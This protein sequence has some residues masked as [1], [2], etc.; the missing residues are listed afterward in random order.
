MGVFLRLMICR[1]I[2]YKP[3][4]PPAAGRL[5]HFINNPLWCNQPVIPHVKT[6]KNAEHLLS[7][8]GYLIF[9]EGFGI[10]PA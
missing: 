2:K 3:A 9:E 8:K 4:P 10:I 6:K 5:I 7:L 1:K